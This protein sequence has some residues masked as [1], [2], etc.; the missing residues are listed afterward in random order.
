MNAS[1]DWNQMRERIIGLGEESSRKSFYP[2][3]RQQLT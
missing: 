2:E 3:L 1:R